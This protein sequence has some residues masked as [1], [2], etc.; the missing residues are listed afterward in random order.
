[1]DESVLS[2]L[3]N[4]DLVESVLKVVL[5]QLLISQ[6][7][8]NEKSNFDNVFRPE[9]VF[10]LYKALEGPMDMKA[11]RH[12]EIIAIE[13]RGKSF[14][15]ETSLDCFETYLEEETSSKLPI[16]SAIDR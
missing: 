2:L 11:T 5:K 14:R 13:L 4:Y 6:K 16:A 3:E 7:H 9:D 8:A 10:R 12:Q 1:M 15:I